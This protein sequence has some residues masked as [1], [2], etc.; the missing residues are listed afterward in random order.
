MS[1][2]PEPRDTSF[3]ILISASPCCVTIG[4]STIAILY[5][6]FPEHK[7]RLKRIHMRDST[8]L[9]GY[10]NAQSHSEKEKHLRST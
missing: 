3:V 4:E 2:P 5:C 7:I 8:T 6:P 1:A 9:G 10:S